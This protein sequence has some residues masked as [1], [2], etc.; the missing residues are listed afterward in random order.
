MEPLGRRVKQLLYPNFSKKF[1]VCAQRP[2]SAPGQPRLRPPYRS[3]SN[4]RRPDELPLSSSA[5]LAA[6]TIAMPPG[7]KRRAVVLEMIRAPVFE[8]R[9]HCHSVSGVP[10]RLLAVASAPPTTFVAPIYFQRSRYRG[11]SL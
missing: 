10:R 2:R 8:Q 4:L 3:P 11:K 1:S 6:Y 9:G 7:D 5:A